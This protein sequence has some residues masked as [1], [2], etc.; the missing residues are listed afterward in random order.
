MKM[1]FHLIHSDEDE[2]NH[3]VNNLFN[4]DNN[5]NCNRDNE[6]I[7]TRTLRSSNLDNNTKIFE[8]FNELK[9]QI[10]L[11]KNQNSSLEKRIVNTVRLKFNELGGML[12]TCDTMDFYF[13]KVEELFTKLAR[14]QKNLSIHQSYISNNTVPNSLSCHRFPKPM[15]QEDQGFVEKY[16]QLINNQ[17]IMILKLNVEHIN[18]QI[19][20]INGDLL[21]LKT[22]LKTKSV[23]I[24][25]H[26]QNIS[27]KV[28][29]SLKEEFA[30]PEVVQEE[31]V[32]ILKEEVPVAQVEIESEHHNNKYD[33]RERRPFNNRYDRNFNKPQDASNKVQSEETDR[34]GR[35]FQDNNNRYNF[36]QQTSS[37]DGSRFQHDNVRGNQ[38]RPKVDFHVIKAEEEERLN[39]RFKGKQEFMVYSIFSS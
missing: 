7:N 20:Q 28:E 18:I 36:R 35:K 39:E 30:F 27:N 13:K 19:D 1:I 15:F 34:H 31:P 33:D 29:E 17:Q 9:C 16:N 4:V 26:F 2:S 23:D 12:I 8:M 6:I 32:K 38:E 25:K 10:D 3:R 14:C 24:E 37:Q 11:I 22:L 5:I 21:N